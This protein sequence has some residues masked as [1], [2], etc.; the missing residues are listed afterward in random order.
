[1]ITNVAASFLE[2]FVPARPNGTAMLVAAGGGLSG[3]SQAS[4]AYPAAR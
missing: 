4:E 1:M 2:T 3:I